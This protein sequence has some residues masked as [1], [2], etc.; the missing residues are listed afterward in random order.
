MILLDSKLEVTRHQQKSRKSN[1]I[2]SRIKLA[3]KFSGIEGWQVAR[4]QQGTVHQ[5]D[6]VCE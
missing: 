3:I 4:L 1:R 5:R 6:Q 2:E